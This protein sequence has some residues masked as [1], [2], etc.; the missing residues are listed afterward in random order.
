MGDHTHFWTYGKLPR[1]LEPHRTCLICESI[2]VYYLD[3]LAEELGVDLDALTP[4]DQ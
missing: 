3:D 4:E 1:S 2:E